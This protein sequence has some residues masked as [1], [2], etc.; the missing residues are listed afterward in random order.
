MLTKNV[1]T[2]PVIA[3]FVILSVSGILLMLHAGGGATKAIHE[4]LGIGFILFGV[5]HALANW[6]MT[7]RYLRGIKGAAIVMAIAVSLGFSSID[8][9]ESKAPPIKAVFTTVLHAPLKNV[10]ALFDK[11][12]DVLAGQLRGKGYSVTGTDRSLE[13]IARANNTQPD[14]LLAIVAARPDAVQR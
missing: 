4:W 5:L 9:S 2:T 10:A 3:L 14:T 12:P 13:E 7:R 11:E 1:S 6:N 8:T